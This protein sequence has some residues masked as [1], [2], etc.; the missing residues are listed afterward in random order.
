MTKTNEIAIARRAIRAALK[1]GRILMDISAMHR[2][3]MEA[4]SGMCKNAEICNRL[5]WE[6]SKDVKLG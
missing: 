4:I 2:V 6:A 1:N 3:G 5:A